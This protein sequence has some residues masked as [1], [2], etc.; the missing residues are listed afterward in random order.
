ML[1]PRAIY[2]EGRISCS[3]TSFSENLQHQTITIRPFHPSA[4]FSIGLLGT[5]IVQFDYISCQYLFGSYFGILL[6][7]AAYDY[8]VV[9][10]GTAGLVIASR[11]AENPN[12]T[13]AVVDLGSFYE[14]SNSDQSQ[15]LIY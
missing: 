1:F 14:T 15:I 4:S 8:V 13:I 12:M 5:A 9:G 7:N 11:L 2:M 3:A 6:T 10:G